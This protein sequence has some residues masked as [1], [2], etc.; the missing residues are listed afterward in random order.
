MMDY[1]DWMIAQDEQRRGSGDDGLDAVDM[2]DVIM[3]VTA[4]TEIAAGK[5][6]QDKPFVEF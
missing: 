3:R 4:A 1:I 5:I 6:C 2:L